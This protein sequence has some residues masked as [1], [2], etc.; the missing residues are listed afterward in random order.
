[1]TTQPYE[2]TLSG[3]G[4]IW[5]N[6]VPDRYMLYVE[7]EAT[8]IISNGRYLVSRTVPIAVSNSP[9]WLSTKYAGFGGM[10]QEIVPHG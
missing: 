8:A 2:A 1:M 6:F 5:S 3:N 10:V 7:I 9:T 4:K